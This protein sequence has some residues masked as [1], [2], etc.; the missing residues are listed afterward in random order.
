MDSNVYIFAGG[1][2]GGHVYPGLAVA[3]ELTQLSPQARIVFACSQRAIDR[4][5]LDT[6]P[7][8]VVPQPVRPLPRRAGDLWPFLRAWQR[9]STQARAMIEDL[10]PAAVLGLGGFAAGPIVRQAAKAGVRTGL[11]NPDAVPGKANRVLARYADAIFTQFEATTEAF[12]DRLRSRIRIVGCPVCCAAAP[13]GRQEAIAHFGLES[14]RRTLLVL[15]GST[16]AATI[17]E[18]FAALAGEITHLETPWQVLHITGPAQIVE[19]G[20]EGEPAEPHVHTVEYCD[21]MDL[22]YAAADLALCRAGASTVAELTAIG[23]PAVFMPYPYHA[24]QHQRLNAGAMCGAGAALIC[25]D[26]KVATANAAALRQVLLA[27][28]QDSPRL[29]RMKESIAGLGKPRAAHEI[30]RWLAGGNPEGTWYCT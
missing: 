5:I 4:R 12:S 13:G 3:E 1:G 7:H 8:A 19:V 29:A 10:R 22:A 28:M 30:A 18:A 16:G 6:L 14:G 17:N 26:A 27:L 21:R 2:T 20:P 9:S 23:T 11:L 25:E 24:D 15:G